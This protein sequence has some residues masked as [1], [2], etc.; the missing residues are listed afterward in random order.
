M[1]EMQG[2][3]KLVLRSRAWRSLT[4]R[5]TLP[6]V[7]RFADLPA[8]ARALEIGSGG[9]FNAE[10]LLRRFSGWNLTASDIDPE[11]VSLARDRLAPFGGRVEVAEIDAIR[12]GFPDDSF[13]VVVALLVW[14]HV[15]DWRAATAEVAR[16]LRPGGRFLLVGLAAGFFPGPI[17]KLFPP[18]ARYRASEVP[19]ALRD[20]GFARW[21]IARTG[22]FAYRALAEMPDR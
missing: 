20:A 10:V 13:D 16:I 12:T 21:R 8:S 9:G 1:P 2:L 19:D 11:M 22:P 3:E 17:A 4:Q 18:E 14:H 15:G 5:V 6:W 7:L